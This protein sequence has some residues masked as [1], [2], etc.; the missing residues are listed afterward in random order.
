M[1]FSAARPLRLESLEERRLLTFLPAASDPAGLIALAANLAGGESAQS[2]AAGLGG[3]PAAPAVR[4]DVVALHEFGHSLGLSHSEDPNS[5]MY[6]YYNAGY[7]TSNLADDSAVE[8]LLEIYADVHSSGW[9]DLHDADGGISDGDVDLT[10]S[11]VPD[12]VRMDRGGFSTLY[13]TFD[14]L[15]G[16]DQWQQIFAGELARWASVSDGKLSFHEVPDAGLPFNYRGEAQNDPN[17]GDIRIGA[18]RFDSIGKVLALTWFPPPGGYTLAGD[19]NFDQDE[20]WVLEGGA[21]ASRVGP[22][23]GSAS[24]ASNGLTWAG[25]G[26]ALAVLAWI[27]PSSQTRA[28]DSTSDVL[29]TAAEEISPAGQ[30][31]MGR[32]AATAQSGLDSQAT[33]LLLKAGSHTGH[34]CPDDSAFADPD[35]L[36]PVWLEPLSRPQDQ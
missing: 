8:A 32:F 7:D 28:V 18:H 24:V 3:R 31:P 35:L 36:D 12:G 30:E 17:A 25:D 26:E 27:D 9:N 29:R 5:I 21:E 10:Y 1:R 23:G 16:P 13:A 14:G 4:L 20:N 15:F 33:D 22:A 34:A 6:P 19:A 11:F 2:H